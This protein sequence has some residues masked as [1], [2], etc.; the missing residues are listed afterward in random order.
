[1]KI[2][3]VENHQAFTRMAVK[4]FLFTHAVKIVPSLVAARL[5][6]LSEDFDAV[7]MD[8]DL[9]DGKGAELVAELRGRGNKIKIIAASSHEKGNALL[10][11]AGADAVCSKMKFESIAQVLG[12]LVGA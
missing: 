7:I 3:W 4:Q 12:T 2:L 5:A 1:M 8:Y 10:V 11:A 6:I 9:D